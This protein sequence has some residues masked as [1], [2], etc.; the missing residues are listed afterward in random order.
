MS[1][2]N[3]IVLFISIIPQVLFA[4]DYGLLFNGQESALDQRTG[5]HFTSEKPFTVHENL[6]V[7]YNFSLIRGQSDYY[8]Y[9][10]RILNKNGF[11]I[12]LVYDQKRFGNKNIKLIIGQNFSDIGL[13]VD[14]TELFDDWNKLKIAIDF[15]TS[16][17][18]LLIG[19]SVYEDSFSST[20]I[21]EKFEFVMGANNLANYRSTDVPSMRV[22]DVKVSVDGKLKY[23]WPLNSIF[24]TQ[25]VDIISEREAEVQN[26][27]WI[28]SSAEEWNS[29]LE[30]RV[31]GTV[32]T[33]FDS[34]RDLVYMMSPHEFIEY[35]IQS[36]KKRKITYDRPHIINEGAGMLFN[37]L[38]GMLY[39]FFLDNRFISA[40]D[41]KKGEWQNRDIDYDKLTTYWQ[42][43]KAFSKKDSSVYFFGGYGQ[44]NYKSELI[45][46]HFPTN[47]W[48]NISIEHVSPRYLSSIAVVEDSLYI[49]GGY[50]SESGSQMINPEYSFERYSA[51][52]HDYKFSEP[53]IV[54][55]RDQDFVPVNSLI[56]LPNSESFYTLTFPNY[57]L[58]TQLQL[59]SWRK[60]ENEIKALGNSIPFKFKDIRSY[61]DLFITKQQT[62]LITVNLYKDDDD[63]TNIGIYS[64]SF[65]PNGA[66]ISNNYISP[67]LAVVSIITVLAFLFIAIRKIKNRTAKGIDEPITTR[68]DEINSNDFEQHP[69]ISSQSTQS[70]HLQNIQLFGG[71]KISND[72][73]SVINQKLTPLLKELFLLIL[74]HTLKGNGITP[75]E[76]EEILWSDKS[77]KDARNNR[78]V[79]L[80]KLR[81]LF[82]NVEGISITNNNGNLQ[83]IVE[84]AIF[85]DFREYLRIMSSAKSLTDTDYIE[86]FL[87]VVSKG[88]FLDHSHYAWLDKFKSEI[89][90]QII[91]NLTEIIHHQTISDPIKEV[92]LETIFRLDPLNETALINKC[93]MLK[94]QGKHSLAKKTYEQFVT[95]YYSIYNIDFTLS[96]DKII[97]E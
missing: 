4:Q 88:G 92:A 49:Y 64:L 63:S 43:A 89:H 25:T 15:K 85:V 69:T 76:I 72:I 54:N 91:D 45:K 26:P 68:P 30:E 36:K 56:Y 3:I 82:E 74:I 40:I 47:S 93:R 52:I 77:L 58:N 62:K 81:R 9:F 96:F 39:L 97:N 44:L 51:S 35:N 7:E 23:H 55:H 42:T 94:K 13:S 21:G 61:A 80:A 71:F 70:L 32:V 2:K 60:G 79:N 73:T 59:V 78:S 19:D 67:L 50:G 20:A 41:P 27:V 46:Y 75:K 34:E 90:N 11:N 17:V 38:D 12:D 83:V 10:F 65:P 57:K 5:V 53:I 48:H 24:G 6:A 87:A 66:S 95:E 84:E 1:I 16:K 28:R 22:K 37:T 18:K 33:A 29:E 86:P 31:Y 8:G 14:T